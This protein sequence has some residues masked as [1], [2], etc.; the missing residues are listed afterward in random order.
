MKS[1]FTIKQYSEL[2][3]KEIYDVAQENGVSFN[4]S[5]FEIGNKLGINDESKIENIYQILDNEN[6]VKTISPLSNGDQIIHISGM[7][8]HLIETGG[9]TGILSSVQGTVVEF[10]NNSVNVMGNNYGQAFNQSSNINQTLKTENISNVINTL[11]HLQNEILKDNNLSV[12][13]KNE[14][15]EDINVAKSELKK[16]KP[17]SN[18]IKATLENLTSITSI[19]QKV[20]TILKDLNI[21]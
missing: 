6:L 14:A 15:L 17:R 4:Q 1:P 19:S 18:I 13:I 12:E 21:L 11:D 16:K 7:G 2:F 3:L 8:E 9:I 5:I 20:F 10:I